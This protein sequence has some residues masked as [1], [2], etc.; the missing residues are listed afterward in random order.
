MKYARII[1]NIVVEITTNNPNE[2]FHPSIAEQFTQVPD[3]ITPESKLD[4]DTGEWI[5]NTSYIDPSVRPVQVVDITEEPVG[6]AS[7]SQGSE[8]VV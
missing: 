3:D 2:I 6:I 5:I 1:D 7:T 4:P 8:E